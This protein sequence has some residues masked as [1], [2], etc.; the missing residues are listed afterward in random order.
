MHVDPQ[1]ARIL[2]F[3]VRAVASIQCETVI[4]QLCHVD[5]NSSFKSSFRRISFR[6]DDLYVRHIV[7]VE[8]LRPGN[9]PGSVVIYVECQNHD[10]A[11]QSIPIKQ[12]P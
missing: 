10:H 3:N 5:S 12:K 4:G 6:V 8:G 9:G 2:H 1:H 11:S 7:V